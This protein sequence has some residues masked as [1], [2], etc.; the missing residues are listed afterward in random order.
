[1]AKTLGKALSRVKG[2]DKVTGRAKYTADVAL[3]GLAYGVIF[4]SAIAL[5]RV[6]EI[7][8]SAAEGEGILAI[9]THL[10]APQFNPVKMFPHGPFGET[11]VPLQGDIIHH[12]D[13]I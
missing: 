12:L 9:I 6:V 7:D 11:L 5:G 3:S 2:I 4:D 8:T 10:N 1:M 13:S